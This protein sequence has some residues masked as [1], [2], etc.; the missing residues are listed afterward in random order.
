MYST[1]LQG[2]PYVEKFSQS[3]NFANHCQK[4]GA[5]LFATK[6]FAKADLIHCIT[7]QHGFCVCVARRI[8]N[9]RWILLSIIRRHV[10]VAYVFSGYSSFMISCPDR[11]LHNAQYYHVPRDALFE[12]ICVRRVAGYI[13]CSLRIPSIASYSMWSHQ[14]CRALYN[15][16]CAIRT[17]NCE[18]TVPASIQQM[19]YRSSAL[20]QEGT[21]P[22]SFNSNRIDILPAGYIYARLLFLHAATFIASAL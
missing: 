5:E 7:L 4:G 13:L 22:A 11:T 15:V 16:Q 2:I 8:F 21:G 14:F 19:S 3:N 18:T 9:G 6:I 1:P 12:Y 10:S 17:R 20:F